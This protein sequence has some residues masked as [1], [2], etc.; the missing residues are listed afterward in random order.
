MTFTETLDQ[1]LVASGVTLPSSE[2]NC[3]AHPPRLC[4]DLATHRPCA[5]VTTSESTPAVWFQSKGAVSVAS[6]HS[7][8]L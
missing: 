1:N 5:L 6:S 4:C 2:P 7:G 8:E 3:K